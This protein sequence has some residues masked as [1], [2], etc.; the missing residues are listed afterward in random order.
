MTTIVNS[1]EE[2]KGAWIR[3]DVQVLEAP[4][5]DEESKQWRALANAYGM[6][7]IIELRLSPVPA[8]G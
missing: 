1:M 5:Y 3:D 7:A 4:T 6:L 8:N 2:L